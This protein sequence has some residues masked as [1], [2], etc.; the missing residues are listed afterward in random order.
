MT[1]T[2]SLSVRILF[3]LIFLMAC[4]PIEQVPPA[5]S[6]DNPQESPENLPVSPL[7]IQD[8]Q[9]QVADVSHFF[10]HTPNQYFHCTRTA[11]GDIFTVALYYYQPNKEGMICSLLK[12]ERDYRSIGVGGYYETHSHMRAADNKHCL[13]MAKEELNRAGWVCKE[14]ETGPEKIQISGPSTLY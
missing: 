7:G 5:S 12:Y 1:D 2:G 4:A 8:V 14:V 13:G 3:F 9:K 11:D 6:T 10:K